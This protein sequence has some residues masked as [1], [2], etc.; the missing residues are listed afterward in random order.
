V[1][2][3]PATW[4]AGREAEA[5]TNHSAQIPRRRQTLHQLDRSV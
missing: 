5:A 2:Q 4:C 3:K 1:R